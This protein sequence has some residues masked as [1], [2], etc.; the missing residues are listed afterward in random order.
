MSSGEELQQGQ[1]IK[2]FNG[3]GQEVR[4]QLRVFSGKRCESESNPVI[5]P[6]A[7]GTLRAKISVCMK[8]YTYIVLRASRN[9][10][11]SIQCNRILW[12]EPSDCLVP[13]PESSTY[14][15]AVSS[16]SH[17]SCD[18]SRYLR[19]PLHF[20]YGCTRSIYTPTSRKT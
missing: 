14:C 18:V 12:L 4:Q 6:P 20:A 9:V 2:C 3:Q 7:P 13:S 15:Q 10:S 19:R 17:L 5:A 16:S 8:A 1:C 11:Q